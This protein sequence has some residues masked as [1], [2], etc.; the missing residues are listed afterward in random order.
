[1]HEEELSSYSNAGG[2]H[3][4]IYSLASAKY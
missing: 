3:I 2:S 1:V 4:A